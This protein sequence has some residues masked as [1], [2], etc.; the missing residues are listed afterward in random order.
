MDALAHLFNT[1][2]GVVMDRSPYSD[3]VFIEAM[4]KCGYSDKKGNELGI[5]GMAD[6]IKFSAW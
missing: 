4:T 5:Y 3:F 6:I 2:Q 1:G